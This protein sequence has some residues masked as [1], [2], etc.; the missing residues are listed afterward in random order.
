MVLVL[1]SVFCLVP[2]A[3]SAGD[4]LSVISIVPFGAN[5]KSP[6]AYDFDV[7]VDNKEFCKP[8]DPIR[9]TD[10]G[11]LCEGSVTAG[12]HVLSAM[13]KPNKGKNA[14]VKGTVVLRAED[15][16]TGDPAQAADFGYWCA[17]VS[18]TRIELMPK[19]DPKC[20]AS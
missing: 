10:S 18:K 16:K 6:T 14:R 12:R 1:A 17:A 5:G 2:L 4:Y 11:Y 7:K 19:S 20:Q 13:I 8:E 15:E 9:S 3:A